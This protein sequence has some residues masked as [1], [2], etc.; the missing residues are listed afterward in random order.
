MY[1]SLSP[2]ALCLSLSALPVSVMWRPRS[3]LCHMCFL[4]PLPFLSNPVHPDPLS[5]HNYPI[6]AVLCHLSPR[7]LSLSHHH[8]CSSMG[9]WHSS[10][11]RTRLAASLFLCVPMPYC[12]HLCACLITMQPSGLIY[13]LGASPVIPMRLLFPRLLLCPSP[14]NRLFLS[15]LISLL[16]PPLLFYICL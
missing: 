10:T 14:S 3:S 6:S 7:F 12:I 13:V 11:L 8:C 2:S 16:Y 5:A 15:L 1:V 9:V 4:C